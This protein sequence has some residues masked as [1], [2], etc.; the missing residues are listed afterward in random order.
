M[1]T[2]REA[3]FFFFSAYSQS[4][5]IPNV[6]LC[7]RSESPCRGVAASAHPPPSACPLCHVH[8]A[9]ALYTSRMPSAP[10]RRPCHVHVTPPSVRPL[11]P[12]RRACHTA[13]TLCTPRAPSPALCPLS[14]HS[15]RCPVVSC[16][17]YAAPARAVC[18]PAVRTVCHPHRVR[19]ASA[20][21][22]PCTPP[23]P[24]ARGLHVAPPFAC[25]PRH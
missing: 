25:R 16:T 22:T 8:A 14:V 7:L 24:F 13:P 18:T 21:R 5:D 4:R 3:T 1:H 17:L 11:R 19:T 23:L 2:K 20:L 6:T 9:N 15:A 12:L 10:T